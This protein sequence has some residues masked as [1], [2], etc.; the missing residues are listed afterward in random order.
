MEAGAV[1]IIEKL[2]AKETSKI[3]EHSS[4]K[5]TVQARSS[6]MARRCQRTLMALKC[7][8]GFGLFGLGA[9]VADADERYW[10]QRKAAF[11]IVERITFVVQLYAMVIIWH[12]SVI[13]PGIRSTL[14]S[15]LA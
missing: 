3:V 12:N 9:F 10:E 6:S 8:N 2:L 11:E 14:L 15:P 13:I 4:E 5:L 7:T 1:D